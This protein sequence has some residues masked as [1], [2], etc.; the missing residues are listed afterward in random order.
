MFAITLNKTYE[1]S[2]AKIGLFIIIQHFWFS[3]YSFFQRQTNR[4]D[5]CYHSCEHTYGPCA[6]DF[7]HIIFF[8]EIKNKKKLVH[9]FVKVI[10]AMLNFL[11]VSLCLT[12]FLCT[13][14]AEIVKFEA[15]DTNPGKFFFIFSL[16]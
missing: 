2:S 14:N 16:F 4:I 5:C 11:L 1:L 12:G 8:Q 15:C 3:L 6:H 9:R 7:F 13:I 10:M